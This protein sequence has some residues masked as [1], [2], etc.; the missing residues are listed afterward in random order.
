M[1]KPRRAGVFALQRRHI[2]FKEL[3]ELFVGKHF[4]D[5]PEDGLPVFFVELPDKPHL[6]FSRPIHAHSYWICFHIE[7]KVSF[8]CG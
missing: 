6:L 8:I 4:I 7:Q 5:E 2:I 3:L 1:T